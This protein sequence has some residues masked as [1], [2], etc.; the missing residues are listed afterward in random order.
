MNSNQ[1]VSQAKLY[2]YFRSFLSSKI[3]SSLTKKIFLLA[4]EDFL[5]EKISFGD[6]L[7]IVYE[8]GFNLNNFF[9][10]FEQDH[11]LAM[12]LMDLD[13]VDQEAITEKEINEWRQKLREYYK[14]ASQEIG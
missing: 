5:A 14:F 6:L 13:E 9:D 1:T 3:D 8:L 12:I 2:S 11:R 4:I 10:L 7:Y